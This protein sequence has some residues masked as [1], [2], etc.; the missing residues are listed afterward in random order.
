[1]QIYKEIVQP[2]RRGPKNVVGKGSF[3]TKGGSS[4]QKE[5]KKKQ[6]AELYGDMD[7]FAAPMTLSAAPSSSD[8][9]QIDAEFLSEPLE[10]SS[11]SSLSESVQNQFEGFTYVNPD[12][13]NASAAPSIPLPSPSAKS[14]PAPA[15]PP[16]VPTAQPT[17]A[18]A[19]IQVKVFEKKEKK[20]KKNKKNNTIK[21]LE[22][23]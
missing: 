12:S 21:E 13:I 10:R 3:D 20:Q 8:T 7:E 11:S 18:S 14:A 17:T 5:S 2:K 4:K 23:R 1:M 15:P 16:P 22:P 19:G 9:C 6:V